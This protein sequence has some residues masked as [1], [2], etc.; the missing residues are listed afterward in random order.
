MAT[1]HQKQKSKNQKCLQEMLLHTQKYDI[2]VICKEKNM[3]VTDMPWWSYLTNEN[4][5][6]TE[7][8]YVKWYGQLSSNP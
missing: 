1:N 3:Y 4:S 8:E 7:F 5:C 6:Q 2:N